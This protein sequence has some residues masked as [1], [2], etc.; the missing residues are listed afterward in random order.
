MYRHKVLRFFNATPQKRVFLGFGK[1]RLCGA[2]CF[3]GVT[4]AEETALK[5]RVFFR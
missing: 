5:H 1:L 3:V 2:T 4:V